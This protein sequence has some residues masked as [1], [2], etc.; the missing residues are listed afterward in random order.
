MD[1][2]TKSVVFGVVLVIWRQ[3]QI[4]NMM[5]LN[6]YVILSITLCLKQAI[7]SHST[8]IKTTANNHKADKLH[9]NLNS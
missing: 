8:T 4:D 1:I 9:I 7:F 2:L 3:L 6:F 5:L